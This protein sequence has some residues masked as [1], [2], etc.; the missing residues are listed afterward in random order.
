MSTWIGTS[1]VWNLASNWQDPAQIPSSSD[2]VTIG[3][4]P[5][6]PVIS[7][8]AVAATLQINAATLTIGGNQNS[9]LTVGGNITNTGTIALA[10]GQYSAG[11]DL[12]VAG[13]VLGALTLSGGGAV[14]L[15]DSANN[16]IVAGPDGVTLTTNNTISGAGSFGNGSAIALV[17]QATGIVDATG[18]NNQLVLYMTQTATNSGLIEDTG[19]AGLEIYRTTIDSSS[20]GLIAAVGAGTHV[21]LAGATLI[22]GTL[23]TSGGGVI[24]TLGSGNVLFGVTNNGSVQVNDGTT[25]TLRGAITNLLG[26]IAVNAGADQ[27]YLDIDPTGATLAGPGLVTLSDSAHNVITGPAG[28]I[29]TNLANVISGAGSFGQGTLTLVNVGVINATG[30]NNQLILQCG[31]GVTNTGLISDTGTAGLLILDT[32]VNS[33]GGGHL[34]A[35][36]PGAHIDL[37]EAD[38]QGG[39]LQTSGEGSQID[40]IG[41]GN[42][43]DGSASTVTNDGTVNI[44]DRTSLELIGTIDNTATIALNATTDTTELTIGQTGATLTGAG[45]VTLSDAT[46]NTLAGQTSTAAFVNQ[47]NTITG[48]GEFVDMTL[49]NAGIIEAT[50]ADNA[51]TLNTGNAIA[52]NG[53]LE[54]D[55]GTLIID[56]AVTGIGAQVIAAAG[57]LKLAGASDGEG[58]TFVGVDDS[59]ILD[60]PTNFALTGAI[61][62]F[63]AGDVIDFASLHYQASYEAVWYA[64]TTGGTLQIIDSA[65][66]NAVV[67]TLAFLGSYSGEAFG[68]A[69]DG[70]AGTDVEIAE[71]PYATPAAGDVLFTGVTGRSYSA[72]EQL[73][74]NGTYEGIDFFY[75]DVSGQPYSAYAYDYSAGNDF[76]GSKFF[77]TTVPTGANY[78]GYEYDYDGGNHVTRID[79]TGVTGVAYSSYEYDFV[80]GVYDGAKFEFTT[81]PSGATYSSY[82][83]DY[84][85]TDAF[86]GD[87]FFFTNLPGQSYTGE[88][89]DFDA[90]G[91]LARVLLTGV[92]GQA[93]SS[94]EE[95]FSAGT[96]TGYKAYYTGITGQSYT[97]VEVDVSATNQLE[98]VVYTGMSGTPYSSVEEDY[99]S[100]ALTDVIYDFTNVT[101]ASA[102]AFQVEDNS[103]GI[104]QQEIY[105]NNDGS[106]TIIGLGAAGQTF[107]SIADDTFTGG[108][109][110][111]TFVFQPIYGS[112]TIMDFYQYTSGATH[113]TISL[114]T[115]EFANFAAVLSGAQNVGVNTVITATNGDTLMLATLNTST[116]ATLSADF[117]FHA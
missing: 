70:T 84:N 5:N 36:E 54:A 105:D 41:Q 46:G 47:D 51:L 56:D 30:T 4:S 87:K 115:S 10:G 101:G 73:Y 69:S 58:V 74:S 33:A 93:Y 42:V 80:G 94:L 109:A 28:A 50:F 2:S 113:D 44:V 15:T 9:T 67:A 62:G 100:G 64:T 78:T 89:E 91:A 48:A 49:T 66:A 97:G 21:D 86:I 17:N 60:Q 88:E 114:S 72:Y 79:F 31:G 116:L 53:F 103:S 24:Q 26:S 104:A 61:A 14:T 106:H 102:Y 27:T 45:H 55:G 99:S 92:T 81:V 18:T 77:Y 63:V 76:I 35:A 6:N 57:T 40:T 68:L 82:E 85:F 32:T 90:N 110:N 25:L 8:S 108:G 75:T 3:S 98:K 71:A 43:L 112:D 22:G 38:L 65:N 37:E 29:L 111:E 12:V 20:G 16:T 13:Q 95:D 11:L 96:Y 107:T 1:N 117:T 83:T 23:S 19:S 7:G 34:T 39:T 52:N 59:L